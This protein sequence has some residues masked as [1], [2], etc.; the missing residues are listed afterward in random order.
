MA[1]NAALRTVYYDSRTGYGSAKETYQ[2]AK[3]I[4]PNVTLAAT[5]AFLKRQEINQTKKQAKYNSYV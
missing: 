5:R 1:S 4:D 2:Q 3:R